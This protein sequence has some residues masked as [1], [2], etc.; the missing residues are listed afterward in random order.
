MKPR[1]PLLCVF[2]GGRFDSM[3]QWPGLEEP[4]Q[5]VTL[6][7]PD[8]DPLAVPAAYRLCCYETRG[9]VAHYRP[10]GLRR[11]L[12]CV[13]VDGP[14]EK[15]FVVISGGTGNPLPL[16]KIPAPRPRSLL[17]PAGP[18]IVKLPPHLTYKLMAYDP[19]AMVAH[20]SFSK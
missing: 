7:R 17:R 18:E 5:I 20:Y 6:S 9:N 19:C 13:L 12:R 1:D 8:E 16:L 2:E 3:L 11:P 15:K 14:A 4:S 10:E